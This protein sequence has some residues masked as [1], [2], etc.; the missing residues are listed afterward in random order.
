MLDWGKLNVL[1]IDV[2]GE[3]RFGWE[4]ILEE[5]SEGSITEIVMRA[6]D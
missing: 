5:G 6:A 1:S 3:E 2:T 4:L